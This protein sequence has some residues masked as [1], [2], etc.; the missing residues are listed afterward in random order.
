MTPG[1]RQA[2]GEFLAKFIGNDEF[3][4]SDKI[5]EMT[6]TIQTRSGAIEIEDLAGHGGGRRDHKRLSGLNKAFRA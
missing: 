5:G 2:V 6:K 1:S 4:V 3:V